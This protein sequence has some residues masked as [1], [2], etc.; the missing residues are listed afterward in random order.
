M[1][2]QDMQGRPLTPQEA[3]SLTADLVAEGFRKWEIG[4][5]LGF[6][7]PKRHGVAEL[8]PPR[9]LANLLERGSPKG[10]RWRREFAAAAERLRARRIASAP[11]PERGG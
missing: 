4:V 10:A 3:Q 11:N 9:G 1:S 8:A 6:A 5:E 2:A 7:L